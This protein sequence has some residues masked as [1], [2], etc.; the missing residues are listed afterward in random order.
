[1]FQKQKQQRLA[2]F[3]ILCL[4]DIFEHCDDD[5]TSHRDLYGT[6]DLPQDG[7][8]LKVK[9]SGFC[10]LENQLFS[11]AQSFGLF[12]RKICF[13]YSCSCHKIS[14]TPHYDCHMPHS[15]S[16]SNFISI[17]YNCFLVCI[18]GQA[19][20][21]RPHFDLFQCFAS[22]FSIG[23]SLDSYLMANIGQFESCFFITF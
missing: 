20:Q 3:R 1:M 12:L 4:L 8:R 16:V 18:T 19:V 15:L 5:P 9:T 17:N 6:A 21:F 14:C 22:I 11:S 10:F 13:L 2:R 7:G 23:G